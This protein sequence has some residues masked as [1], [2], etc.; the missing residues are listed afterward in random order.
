MPPTIHI[1][2]DDPGCCRSL[3]R[4]LRICGYS[5][6]AYTSAAQFLDRFPN[7]DSPGCLLLDYSMPNTDG[8][9]LQE[10]CTRRGCLLPIIFI[11]GSANIP[12]SV[13]ALHRGALNFLCKPVSR[14]VLIP[15]IEEALQHNSELL[16]RHAA[17]TE[18]RRRYETLTAREKEVC[19][20]VVAGMKS[21][22]I[23]ND[24]GISA[25]T[26]KAHRVHVMQKLGIRSILE[27]LH[28]M[29]E[30]RCESNRFVV[31]KVA[32]AERQSHC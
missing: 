22:Q 8:L 15:A 19:E 31:R 9:A 2:D 17:A 13:R 14:N 5:V 26:I 20:R 27:L 28:F 32:A 21:K 1:I 10:E 11:S 29:N 7:L 30:I 18:C 24:F 12:V 16:Q 6:A 3:S 23:A 25:R 4:L